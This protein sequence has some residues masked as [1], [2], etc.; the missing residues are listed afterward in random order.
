MT[1]LHAL[2]LM[3]LLVPAAAQAEKRC[4][5]LDNPATATWSLND[6]AGGWIIMENGSGYRAKGMN[7]IPDLTT[8]EYVYTHAV[9][10]YACACMEVDTDGEGGISRIRSVRQLPLS[11]CRSDPALGWFLNKDQ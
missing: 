8:G 6:A 7:H 1:R 11:R 2:V 4:G 3:M 9:H 10:G 5:W